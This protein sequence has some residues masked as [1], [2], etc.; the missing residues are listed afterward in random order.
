M[1]RVQYRQMRF[2]QVAIGD[3]RLDPKSRDD[4]PAVLKGLQYL[5]TDKREELFG[6]LEAHIR[7]GTDRKVGRPGMD[8]WRILVLGVLKQG[9]GCDF[10]R[11]Q[12][13]AN[14]HRLVRA[15]LA[16]GDSADESRYG[17]QTVV[18]N[19][20]LPA[21]ELLPAV[22]RLVVDGGH[23]VAGKKLGAPLRGRCDSFAVETDVHYPT[24]VSLLW[25]A[26]RCAVRDTARLAKRH[27]V[28]GRRRW[29]HVT[30]G[31]GT[32]FHRV[33][34]TRRAKGCPA[35][36][37][38]Y[39]AR[40]GALPGRVGATLDALASKGV[41]EAEWAVIRGYLEHARR[42]MDQVERRLLLGEA[43]PHE[44][45]VFSIFEPHTRR[46]AKGKAGRPVEPGVPVC[47]LEDQ[48]RFILHRKV[49][50]TGGD[51]DA[52]VP[53]VEEAR[54][55][56]PDL[57]ACGF[58]RGFHSPS[59]RARLDGLLELNALPRK[60]RPSRADRERESEESFAAARRQHPAVES[61]TDALEHRGLDRV[62]AHGADGFE[63]TVAL[64]VL[65]ANPHRLGRLL[66]RRE[67]KRRR[68]AA[69]AGQT[70]REAAASGPP[71]GRVCAPSENPPRPPVPYAEAAP[72]GSPAWQKTPVP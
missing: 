28:G 49:L 29:R 65:A 70:R 19:V 22:G 58:D 10:D 25:D 61:A 44:E 34:S 39:L 40:C 24:D 2:G 51:V 12:D 63:R 21:P 36:V 38:A 31:A 60:G 18:D 23:A 72:P 3:I 45:K 35:R 66:R 55:L 56:H 64:S 71:D 27:G 1:R 5:H 26:M 6:L 14:H 67:F 16:H 11:L 57:R 69:R 52:A 43:I 8:L 15:M 17:F 59:N 7:P 30:R 32:L 4:I 68:R 41:P 13:L 62:R 54:A 20:S 33:R 42:Q 48:Y 50:W 9:L 46:V 53:M 37:E 47:V